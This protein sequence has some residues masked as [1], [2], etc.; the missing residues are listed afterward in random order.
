MS[1]NKAASCL[2]TALSV[3][4]LTQA[5]AYAQENTCNLNIGASLHPYYSWVKNIVGDAANVTS[6]IPSGSDPHAYQP[7]PADMAMLENINVVIVN[8]VGHDEFIKPMLKAIDNPKLV[9]IDTSKGLPLIPSFNDKH[10]AFEDKE[11]GGA[12][13][14]YNSHTYIAITGAIQQMQ[15][16]NRELGKLCP[17]QAPVFTKNLRAYSSKLRNMLHDTL[18]K[19]DGLNLDN[20][21]IATVHDGYSYLFQELGIEVSAVVQPRHGVTPS[22]KQ[23]QD[24]IKRIKQAKVNVLFGEMDYEKKYVDII[25]QETG[26]RLYALSHISNGEYTK[27]H[28]EQTMQ[29]NMDIIVAALSEVAEGSKNMSAAPTS[30]QENI[31]KQMQGTAQQ[32]QE[33][34]KQNVQENL[35]KTLPEVQ[36]KQMQD[37]MSKQTQQVQQGM[38]ENIQKAVPEMQQK[39]MQDAALKMQEKVQENLQKTVPEVQQKQMQDSMGKQV[40][41]MQG[42][43][44]ENIQ[45][46]VPAMQQQR[47]QDTAQQMQENAKQKVQ[48]VVPA[49]AAQPQEKP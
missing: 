10:Y 16:I 49:P 13:V 3:L 4:S 46:T 44:Q 8:G 19:I 25:F 2:M 15:M 47:M 35:Q 43:M 39:Q 17:E 14:S 1:M 7:V 11:E 22:T 45:K 29:K 34:M 31:S 5:P 41:Q 26:C 9:V 40:Q 6:L 30:I 24:T 33:K 32:M 23:L 21:R 36:Q 37:S 20:L 38:K 48:N 28:F 18:S 12:K 27:E 42:A